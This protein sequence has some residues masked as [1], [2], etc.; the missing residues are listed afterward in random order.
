M[1]AN[2]VRES[3][4]ARQIALEILHWLVPQKLRSTAREGPVTGQL[5]VLPIYCVPVGRLMRN[6][7]HK[8]WR[9]GWRYFWVAEHGSGAIV[10]ISRGGKNGPVFSS[11]TFGRKAA[12]IALTLEA[13]A[14]VVDRSPVR[15]RPRLLSLAPLHLEAIWLNSDPQSEPEHFFSLTQNVSNESFLDLAKKRASGLFEP[16]RI[17]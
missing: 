7:F 9:W 5:G 12:R 8:G 15:Y 4:A 6:E 13:A 16:V 2:R 11:F 3:R 1:T 10:N 17:S 14:K